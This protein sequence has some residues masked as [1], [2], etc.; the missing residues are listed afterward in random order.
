M[1]FVYIFSILCCIS[2]TTIFCESCTTDEALKCFDNNYSSDCTY[3][4]K[5][6]FSVYAASPVIK[7]YIGKNMS[8]YYV[9][10][11]RTTEFYA[12][13]KEWY[14]SLPK[15]N[16]DV[17]SELAESYTQF[18]MAEIMFDFF[19]YQDQMLWLLC[20]NWGL[21]SFL[22]LS[23]ER[24]ML[25]EDPSFKSAPEY[26]AYSI[27]KNFLNE[28]RFK[29][30]KTEDKIELIYA[31]SR[32]TDVINCKVLEKYDEL[33]E[34][35]VPLFK[36]DDEKL[37][38]SITIKVDNK[39][40]TLYD[41]LP[42]FLHYSV[43]RFGGYGPNINKIADIGF[44]LCNCT[45]YVHLYAYAD[46]AFTI[47]SNDVMFDL[48]EEC[49]KDVDKV[50]EAAASLKPEYFQERWNPTDRASLYTPYESAVFSFLRSGYAISPDVLIENGSEGEK[51]KIVRK[52]PDSYLTF[53]AAKTNP[54][55]SEALDKELESSVNYEKSDYNL[56]L[57]TV[58][59]LPPDA[60]EK[61][62]SCLKSLPTNKYYLK[63]RFGSES[64]YSRGR[65]AES[66][67]DAAAAPKKVINKITK[68]PSKISSYLSS[69]GKNV[70]ECKESVGKNTIKDV[71]YC[72]CA[73]VS[74]SSFLTLKN[75]LLFTAMLS[76]VVAGIEFYKKY[77][78]KK[79]K[80]CEGK[81]IDPYSMATIY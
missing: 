76:S 7:Q 57:V 54:E 33:R 15:E 77:K 2:C 70:V 24:R 72:D 51:V 69:G 37:L 56:G 6:M 67:Y 11:R 16:K 64:Y 66:L 75:V 40:M 50:W 27:L 13:I 3:F 20:E 80:N 49:I 23:N 38:K 29:F 9:P 47:V 46:C 41:A 73:P 74:I 78:E 39:D 10:K 43:C 63:D 59:L 5:K 1:N 26:K 68:L 60:K 81:L 28:Q 44:V 18:Q 55:I 32:T 79:D 58:S 8:S 48:Y 34:K 30:K 12:D 53:E 31:D 19:L 22:S 4:N 14:D 65:I 21:P 45:N 71:T 25:E 52:L 61:I 42:Q 62:V 36:N 35:I 17:L